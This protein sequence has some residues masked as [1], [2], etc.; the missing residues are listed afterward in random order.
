MAS[1][2]QS[3]TVTTT[4]K[5]LRSLKA[6]EAVMEF[7]G[8]DVAKGDLEAATDLVEMIDQVRAAT[9][10]LEKEKIVEGK[11]A[12]QVLEMYKEPVA[13]TTGVCVVC[14]SA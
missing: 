12:D 3:V 6:D 11:H 9:P 2:G 14:V 1:G 5:Y 10:K 8:G 7:C 4:D 13:C